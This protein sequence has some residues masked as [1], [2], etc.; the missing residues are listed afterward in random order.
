MTLEDTP[1]VTE[2]I[3]RQAQID[4]AIQRLNDATT[5]MGWTPSAHDAVRERDAQ[6]AKLQEWND[7][8]RVQLEAAEA[9]IAS[10]TAQVERL[11]GVFSRMSLVDDDMGIYMAGTQRPDGSFTPRDGFGDG[12][13]A[14]VSQYGT[15][16]LAEAFELLDAGEVRDLGED[17]GGNGEKYGELVAFLRR[18][19]RAEAAT[20][21]L[22]AERDAA[23]QE[24]ANQAASIA[25][26]DDLRQ[27]NSVLQAGLTAEQ[28][29]AR[30]FEQENQTLR[31]ALQ[32]QSALLLKERAE[33]GVTP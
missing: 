14:A 20:A 23:Q 28:Q 12:W 29:R 27:S 4:K 10:L 25:L 18:A 5:T 16:L 13:N 9:Q 31:E 30:T 22:R 33:R 6:I 11:K 15:A 7:A 2:R 8:Q 1:R 21:T 3:D 24:I 19:K 26:M 32:T 17:I